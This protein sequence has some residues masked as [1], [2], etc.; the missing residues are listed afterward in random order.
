MSAPHIMN[1][2]DMTDAIQRRFEI[3]KKYLPKATSID[4][5]IIL[6]KLTE[7]VDLLEMRKIQEPI[8]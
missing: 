2:Y 3:I 7:L 5:T 8:L 1:F 4:L 6:N